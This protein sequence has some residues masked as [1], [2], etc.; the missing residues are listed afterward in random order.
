MKPYLYTKERAILWGSLNLSPSFRRG[1]FSPNP[2]K[3]LSGRA[4]ISSRYKRKML[5]LPV[6]M[7]EMVSSLDDASKKRLKISIIG[8]KL[9][10]ITK[11][12]ERE[13][14]TKLFLA[15][16]SLK[17]NSFKQRLKKV[18]KTIKK[19]AIAPVLEMVLNNATPNT[20]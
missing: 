1:A 16:F 15:F 12:V 5:D 6:V 20:M 2:N 13:K 17:R 18:V 8:L 10:A 3:K 19:Y 7:E 14:K 4:K 9:K 11:R